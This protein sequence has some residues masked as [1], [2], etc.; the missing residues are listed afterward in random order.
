MKLDF[1]KKVVLVTGAGGAIGGATALKFA[2]NGADVI[3]HDLKEEAGNKVVNQITA[4]GRKSAFIKADLNIPEEAQ[5]ISE[6]AIELFGKIDILVNNAGFNAKNPIQEFD[7]DEWN[8][9]ININLNSVYHVSKPVIKSM[10]EKK[11]GKIINVGS[12]AG[13]VP[14][15]LQSAYVAAKAGVHEL[16]RAMAIELAQYNIYVNAVLPGSILT[17]GTNKSFYS[18]PVKAEAILSHIPFHRPGTPEEVANAILFL[19]S[20][21]ASYITGSLLV[22]DGGW[23]SGY[24]RDF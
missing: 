21:E 16:T 23:T 24:S 15:R 3:I 6:K 17:E 13:M 2:E 8:R 5:K 14:L 10:I 7:D 4:M 20:D 18:D 19:A 9:A 11:F 12:V 1:N 22:V